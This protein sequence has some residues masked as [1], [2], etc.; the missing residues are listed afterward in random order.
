MT[1][2]NVLLFML[3]L[4]FGAKGWTQEW[5]Q[6][7]DTLDQARLMVTYEIIAHQDT[8]HINK[9]RKENMMLCLGD[10]ISWFRSCNDY[11]FEQ[12]M[13]ERNAQA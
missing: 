13:I 7:Y 6:E 11:R 10:S 4:L 3:A 1:K 2:K 12:N 9:F 8:N 5:F